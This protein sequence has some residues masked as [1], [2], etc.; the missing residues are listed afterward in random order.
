MEDNQLPKI[1]LYG[2]LSTAHRE[3]GALKKRY[4]DSLKMS[5]TACHVDYKSWS[6]NVADGDDDDDAL[7]QSILKTV[8]EFENRQKRSAKG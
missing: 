6:D 4:K 1:V 8:N 2:E 3:R 5:P 7:C